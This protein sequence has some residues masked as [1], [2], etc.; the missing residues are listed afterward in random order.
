MKYFMYCRKSTESEDRQVLSIES[1][2]SENGRSL[3]SLPDAEIVQVFEESFS[4]KAP[5]RPL[6]DE[7]L[8]RIERGE[9]EGIVAWHPDR[10]ARNSLD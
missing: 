7:M 6:F 9:A 10:L 2:R 1:Q 4:A 8:K 3:S 5:G